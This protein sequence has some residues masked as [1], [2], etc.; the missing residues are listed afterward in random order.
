[1]AEL[2]SQKPKSALA[3]P[4]NPL[5]KEP[6]LASQVSLQRRRRVHLDAVER[7][8]RRAQD[9]V[10]TSLRVRGQACQW[11]I[12]RLHHQDEHQLRVALTTAPRRD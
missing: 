10:P 11:E 12:I 7:G 4:I 9:E 1:M 3:L 2:E 6:R 8:P 5:C